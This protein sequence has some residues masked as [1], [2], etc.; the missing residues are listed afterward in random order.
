MSD[1][2]DTTHLVWDQDKDLSWFL[3]YFNNNTTRNISVFHFNWDKYLTMS[4]FVICFKTNTKI[5]LDYF[6][7]LRPISS[8][9]CYLQF[10]LLNSVHRKVHHKEWRAVAD[11]RVVGIPCLIKNC[12]LVLP[13]YPQYFFNFSISTHF[14]GFMK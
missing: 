1:F 11:L 12:W 2:C 9:L 4:W 7:N 14:M 13:N 8:Y 5:W 6:F 3:I 10:L